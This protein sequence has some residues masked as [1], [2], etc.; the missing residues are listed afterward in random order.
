MLLKLALR[1]QLIEMV[2]M[3]PDERVKRGFRHRLL[4]VATLFP[5]VLLFLPTKRSIAKSR[6][7]GKQCSSRSISMLPVVDP[8]DL[9]CWEFVFLSHPCSSWTCQVC[10][11]S[12]QRLDLTA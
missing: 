6:P 3:R 10:G 1:I 9:G 12:D 11:T 4:R 2:L 8:S 5:T 7:T